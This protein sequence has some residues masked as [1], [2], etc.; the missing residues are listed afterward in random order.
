MGEIERLAAVQRHEA[1]AGQRELHHQY[2]AGLSGGAI[3]GVLLHLFDPG[4]GQQR[5]IEVCGLLGLAIEPQAG[6][7]F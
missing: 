3:D 7:N 2:R 1:L 5:N 6:G 4:I